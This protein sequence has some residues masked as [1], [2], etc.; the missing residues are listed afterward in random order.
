M[1]TEN[2]IYHSDIE[3]IICEDFYT[4]RGKTFLITGASGLVGTA[5]VDTL[6]I[7]NEKF[8]LNLK[9]ILVSRHER[10]SKY[11]FIKI[12]AHDITKDLSTDDKIDYIIH[13]ASNTH[14]RLYAEQPVE[15]IEVN[16]LGTLNIL[17]LAKKNPDVRTIFLSTLEVYGENANKDIFS[18]TDIGIT[19][20]MKTRAC[21]PESKRLCETLCHSFIQEYGAD[22]LIARLGY[23]YGPTVNLESS[24]ADVQFLNNALKGES[25]VMK[26]QGL[27]KRSYIYVFDVVSALLT[28]LI[29]GK[30]G[31]TYNIAS[32]S[33]N[34]QLKD[35]STVLSEIAGIKT[36]LEL[37]SQKESLGYSTV[38]NSTLDNSKLC[39]I[40]WSENFTFEEGVQHTFAIKKETLKNA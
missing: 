9:L 13:A 35:F 18:E 22:I 27:Q 2:D 29:K 32:K 11:D 24:K 17:K 38:I 30:R 31:E 25:I 6:V 37:P 4:F 3:R 19:N 10:K 39:S 8:S 5:L 21:Y 40:G 15:T 12:I 1:Y 33:G 7:L 26:S 20:F 23:V 16:I 14:P 28:L 34:K 36:K